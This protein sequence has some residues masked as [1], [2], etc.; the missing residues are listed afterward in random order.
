MKINTVSVGMATPDK[1]NQVT[2]EAYLDEGDSVSGAVATLR[3]LIWAYLNDKPLPSS[4]EP[5]ASGDV[6]DITGVH[7]TAGKDGNTVGL[8]AELS[9]GESVTEVL[10]QLKTEAKGLL[11]TAA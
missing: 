11:N 6:P 5:E 10:E 4:Q 9:P 3:G 7:Y 1:S 8:T 2:L